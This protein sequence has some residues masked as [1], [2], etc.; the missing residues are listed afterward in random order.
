ME[1]VDRLDVQRL[2]L[3]RG[4]EHRVERH[5]A[6]DPRA[7]V[8]REQLVR[9]RRQDEV[10][11]TQRAPDRRPRSRRAAPARVT[12]PVSRVAS[13]SAGISVIHSVSGSANITVTSSGR[14]RRESSHSRA[15]RVLER[16]GQQ[17][18]ERAA[19]R[20]RARASGRR[21]R[22][23]PA[24]RGAPRS[25]RR[26]A[27][28]GSS[29][30]TAARARGRAGARSPCAAFR[31]PSSSPRT[32]SVAVLMRHSP[33]TSQLVAAA[34]ADE[35]A[36]DDEDA[37]DERP[38]ELQVAVVADLG[39]RQA[40]HDHRRGRRDE[41]H[42]P[43]ADWYAVTATARDTPAKSA[44]GARIGITSA[45]CPDDD[46]TRNAIGMLTMNASTPNAPVRRARDRVLHPVQDRV[47]H[48]ARSSSRP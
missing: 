10:G 11:R 38:D 19:P 14:S 45:A 31:P 41:V 8:A 27:A 16:L 26:R 23:A 40:A 47:G 25:R 5:A 42:E 24:A 36:A 17:L 46:G 4:P 44:S 32:G 18:V 29:S 9:Q 15:S 22:R 48:V 34:I 1:A 37:D 33:F 6:V 3:A 12:P 39:Q 43:D 30:A 7:R 35:H 28:R 20:R 21:T 13:S 2:V